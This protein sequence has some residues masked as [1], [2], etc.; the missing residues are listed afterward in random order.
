MAKPTKDV[1]SS[2]VV[3]ITMTG[4]TFH[5]VVAFLSAR[6]LTVDPYPPAMQN[7]DDLPTYC[8]GISDELMREANGF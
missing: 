5:N 3:Q 1:A 4:T 8:V 6:G 2:D 7:E